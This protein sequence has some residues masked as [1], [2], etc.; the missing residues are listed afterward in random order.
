[1]KA[2]IIDRRCNLETETAPLKRIEMPVPEPG[3]GE[4]L[5]RI[6]ACGICHTE[7]DEIEGR[8]PPPV[9]PVIPGHQVI[10]VVEKHR[11]K[12][13]DIHEGDR[14]GVAWIYAACGHCEYCLSHRE[15]LCR[16]FMATGRDV[17]GGY[18]EYMVAREDYVYPIPEIFSDAEAAP[19][20]CAGAIGYRS[21]TLGNIRDGDSLGF[22][23]FG[24]SAHLM[25]KLVQFIYPR[26]AMYV[27][28]RHESERKFALELG[29]DWAG[30]FMSD[31]PV[32]L[33]CIIDTTPVWGPVVEALRCLKPGGRLVINAIRKEEADQH[34]LQEL[35]Y[36]KHL[37]MEKEIKSVAN[38]TRNDVT[39]FISMAAA[40]PFRPE[41]QLYPFEQA[42]T[43]ILDIKRRNI[44][45]AKVLMLHDFTSR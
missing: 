7:I 13:T 37:W 11:G 6:K 33:N 25:V 12:R 4:I 14:V 39:E 1:M 35:N 28:A 44:R 9:Y 34:L 19:L 18:A 8:T 23:G 20:L 42:N 21:L 15:N 3:E 22:T 38:V 41:V 16:D 45:G 10:G 5:L 43:A 36:S 26:S 30:D 29:C 32:E 27:F 40:M 17:H 31:P 24:A 2:W